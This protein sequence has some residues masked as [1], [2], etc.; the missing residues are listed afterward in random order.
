MQV[1]H[2]A[3]VTRHMLHVTRHTSH[4]TLHTTPCS[5]SSSPSSAL[6]SSSRI[7]LAAGSGMNKA[8]A[9]CAR[10]I[11]RVTSTRLDMLQ[12]PLYSAVAVVGV[13]TTSC[14][15][16]QHRYVDTSHVTR[17]TSHAT[18]HTSH[19]TRHTSHVTRHTS[20]ASPH[21]PH[22]TPHTLQRL[23]HRSRQQ[24]PHTLGG[25]AQRTA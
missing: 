10:C 8:V 11:K 22:L 7:P 1:M 24:P 9:A 4:A 23:G 2:R 21:T 3:D 17:H 5:I 12:P 18:R 19:V 6:D 16:T 13:H 15:G 14:A 25:E 20:H